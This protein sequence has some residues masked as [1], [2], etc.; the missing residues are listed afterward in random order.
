MPDLPT[1]PSGW[2]AHRAPEMYRWDAVNED[3]GRLSLTD[4]NVVTGSVSYSARVSYAEVLAVLNHLAA[5]TE[6]AKPKE[7][8][9]LRMADG[10]V[11][12][13]TGTPEQL[14]HALGY[15]VREVVRPDGVIELHPEGQ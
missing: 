3:G 11:V 6:A 12:N 8:W 9:R 2:T 15:P 13:W 5:L 1:L 4:N 14:R 7:V 10:S